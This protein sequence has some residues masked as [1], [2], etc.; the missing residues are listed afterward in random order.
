MDLGKSALL[1][2]AVYGL[3]ELVKAIGPASWY[4]NTNQKINA[5]ATAATAVVVGQAATFLV[6]A[7]VWAH[8]QVL[9]GKALDNLNVASKVLVGVFVAAAAAFGDRALNA[10]KNVGQ[11]QVQ[12]PIAK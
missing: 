1:I 4:A 9:N 5:R 7:S 6:A 11:N 10:V 3:T 2:A 8:S 12:R